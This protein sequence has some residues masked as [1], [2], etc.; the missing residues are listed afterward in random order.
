M[1]KEIKIGKLARSVAV[2]REDG[3]A[4]FTVHWIGVFSTKS[5]CSASFDWSGS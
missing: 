2:Y 3:N 1:G 4:Y 5:D